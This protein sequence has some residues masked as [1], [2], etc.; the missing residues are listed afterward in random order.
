[1]AKGVSSYL[2]GSPNGASSN[3]LGRLG[4]KRIQINFGEVAKIPLHR[5]TNIRS[6]AI[7]LNV[8]K[9]TLHRRINKGVLRKHS[10]VLK[11]KLIE[12]NMKVKVWS[13]LSMIKPFSLLSGQPMFTNMY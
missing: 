10:S 6:L 11:P 9:S 1:M 3:T 8:S 12:E 13:C 5:R 7:A 2:N 4:C